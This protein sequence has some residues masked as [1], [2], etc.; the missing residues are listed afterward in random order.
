MYMYMFTHTYI[1]IYIYTFMCIY[2]HL[3]VYTCIYVCIHTCTRIYIIVYLCIYTYT[4]IYMCIYKC[5]NIYICICTNCMYVSTRTC[6]YKRNRYKKQQHVYM[7]IYILHTVYL[8]FN[9]QKRIINKLEVIWCSS[10]QIQ[11]SIWVFC[12]MPK[13]IQK[14][15]QIELDQPC[16]SVRQKLVVRVTRGEGHACPSGMR[17]STTVTFY[18]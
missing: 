7:Y 11:V 6:L 1:Y 17:T 9:V 2:I 8:Q 15:S 14:N 12:S 4:Y 3:C 16:Q 10:L 13:S 5:T 18:G